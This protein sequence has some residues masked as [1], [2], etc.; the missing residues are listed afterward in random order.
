MPNPTAENLYITWQGGAATATQVSLFDLT[1]RQV[2]SHL[3][4]E[5]QTQLS[6]AGSDFAKG[7]YFVEITEGKHSHTQKVIFN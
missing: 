2:A 5:G 1:G 4:K 7:V 6:L 3:V